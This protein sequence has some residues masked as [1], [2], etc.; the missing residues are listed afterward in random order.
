MTREQRIIALA[1]A[2]GADIK[3]LTT[4]QGDLT[5][6]STSAKTNL[7][8][9][10]N[11]IYAL[12]G[13]GSVIN[14]TAGDGV[15]NTTWSANKIFDSIALAKQE[16]VNSLTNGASAAYDT[17]AELQALMIADDG[18]TTALATS[19]GF[20]VRFDAAQTLTVGE[21]LQACQNIGVGDPD[22]NFITDY[23][24]AKA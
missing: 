12:L 8:V 11:E 16:V 19:I 23:N 20:R 4:K 13:S 2:V 17:F 3:T 5:S 7:V 21:K 6:L 14:D 18:L 1:Q 10:I 9:A 22:Y 15:T 24:L